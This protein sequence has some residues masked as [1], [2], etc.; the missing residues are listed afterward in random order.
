MF[1][2]DIQKIDGTN[3]SIDILC[4]EVTF[5][6]GGNGS[7]KSSLIN[8]LYRQHGNEKSVYIA[9][10]RK[11]TFDKDIIDFSNSEYK[12]A[13][14]RAFHDSKSET[15]RY[16]NVYEY[17]SINLPIVTLKNKSIAHAIEN[18]NLL[19]RGEGLE[20]LVLHTEI[21]QINDIFK[22]SGLGIEF[23]IDNESNLMANN[24]H[25]SPS[26]QY[27][28]S[29]M[30]DGEKSALIICCQVLCADHNALIVLDEPERHLHK[31]IVSHLLSNLIESRRD[32]AFVISTHELS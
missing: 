1:S 13:K 19:K 17:E 15:S 6:V 4:G 11:N 7:G 26:R 28:L 24:F 20:N 10:H 23:F 31:K 29:K 30:S 27:P 16:R 5:F 22:N 32:C 14:Q 3:S 18:H 25:Y 2:F 8:Q 21:D 12:D 9:A